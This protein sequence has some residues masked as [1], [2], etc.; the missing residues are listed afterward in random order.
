MRGA[1]DEEKLASPMFPR[2]HVSDTEKGGPRAPPRN[3]MALYEQLSI[4]SQ[5][6]S[7]GSP[8][9]LPLPPN[10]GASVVPSVPRS[11]GYGCERSDLIPPRNPPATTHFAEKNLL[12]SSRGG[13]SNGEIGSREQ[14][15]MNGANGQSLNISKPLVAVTAKSNSFQPSDFSNFKNFSWNKHG[16]ENDFR[17]PGCVNSGADVN[18]DNRRHS[19]SQD[20]ACS[21]LSYSMQS[22]K[23]KK[24]S[25]T[26]NLQARE[27]LRNQHQQNA[28]A[29]QTRMEESDSVPSLKDQTLANASA[30]PSVRV[31]N[32][33]SMKQAHSLSGWDCGSNMEDV[34]KCL[35][36]ANVIL[37]QQSATTQDTTVGDNI[38]VESLVDRGDVNS[39]KSRSESNSRPSLGDDNISPKRVENCS[40]NYGNKKHDSLQMELVERPDDVSESSMLDSRTALIVTPDDVV[41]VIG[42]KQF[43]KARRAIANQQR[44]FAIQVFELHRLIKVQ[45]L[46]ASSPQL[47]HEDD[48]YVGKASPIK[49]L[50]SEYAIEQIPLTVKPKERYQKPL[51]D[52]EF[53]DENNVGKLPLPSV[54]KEINKARPSQQSNNGPPSG[55]PLQAPVASNSNLTPWY[56]PPPGNQW[57]VPVL[58]PS[59]GLVYKPCT[60]SFPPTSG[61]MAPVYGNCNPMGLTPG[62]GDFLNAAYGVP[63]PH[64]EGFGLVSG[65]PPLGQTYFLPYGMPF[66]NPSVSGSVEQMNSFSAPE[67]KDN[68]V[69][70]GNVNLVFPHKSSRSMPSQ[71]SKVISRPEKSQTM[72]ESDVQGS[73]ASSPAE[74][75]GNALPPPHKESTVKAS[76]QIAQTNKQETRASDQIAQTNKQETRASDRN[77]QTNKQQAQVIRVVPHDPRLATESAARI[78][79]SIQKERKHG[80]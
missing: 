33:E 11:H 26:I 6:F 3:K 5:K 45:K 55:T 19:K 9:M 15:S 31:K 22:G 75:R 79:R 73:T 40:E 8:S 41:E 37:N 13:N 20:L 47:L 35:N 57:L 23:L 77:G 44:V 34:S 39:S 65:T 56:F 16:D 48:L 54:N 53:A 1:K 24:G 50:Q 21:N 74:N 59:E 66:L 63:A 60:G 76:D 4:P 61:Y 7:P 64:Q 17:V 78:F 46:M 18:C 38:S 51:P 70:V 68:H 36:G 62:S 69:A 58:S 80:E 42:E 30:S 27:Y 25:E 32:I 29:F 49:K 10:T 52:T 28:K 72:K 14:N 67:L 71:T 2:L 12:C 43:W